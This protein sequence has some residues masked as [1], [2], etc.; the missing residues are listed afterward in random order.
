MWKVDV[1][2]S[3]VCGMAVR[4]KRYVGVGMVEIR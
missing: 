3:E 1:D 4:V 2:R